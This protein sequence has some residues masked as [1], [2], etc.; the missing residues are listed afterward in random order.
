M[1]E[2][3]VPQGERR[4]VGD[5]GKV[6]VYIVGNR[7]NTSG[8][9]WEREIMLVAAESVSLDDSSAVEMDAA[10]SS[11]ELDVMLSRLR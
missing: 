1:P 7:C 5:I 8:E 3:V 11:H 10:F 9:H 6:I 2:A 4:V